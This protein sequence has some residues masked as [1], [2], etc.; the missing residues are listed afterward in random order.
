MQR[1]VVFTGAGI[2]A[3]SGL[4]TFRDSGGL[5]EQYKIEDVA[6][7]EAFDKNPEL[8]LNFYNLRRKQLLDSKPNVA[9]FALNQ[10]SEKYYLNIITQNIDDLHE[11][12]GNKKVLHLH[13]KLK[14]AKSSLDNSLIYPIKGSELKIGDL[15]E[16]GSQLRPN[17]VWFGEAVPKMIDAISITKKADVFIVIGTS[18]NVYPAASLLNYTNNANRIILIDPKAEEE[19]SIEVIKEKATIAVPKLVEELLQ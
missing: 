17:V 18:L 5:W 11:R 19:R 7:P 12:S 6:T 4:G 10:L 8:V 13:G 1:I 16:R 9:H 14:E 3:E 2:S 15:C